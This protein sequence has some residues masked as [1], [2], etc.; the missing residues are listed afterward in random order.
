MPSATLGKLFNTRV[1]LSPSSIIWHRPMG[2]WGGNHGPGG[3]VMAAYWRVYGF[4]HLRADCRG[5]GSA[6]EPYARFE[7]GTASTIHDVWPTA[8]WV[9][10]Y[11][12]DGAKCTG[13]D[14][15]AQ[16]QLRI[17]DDAQIGHVRFRGG[18]RNLYTQTQ[19]RENHSPASLSSYIVTLQWKIVRICQ[20]CLLSWH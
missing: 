18:H 5:P 12:V 8:R 7:Y 14:H 10:T 9:L 6:P 4:G 15:F 3:K 2:G 19:H 11:R 16:T 20:P 17:S 13:P 1:P